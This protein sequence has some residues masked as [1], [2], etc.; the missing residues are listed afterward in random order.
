MGKRNYKSALILAVFLASAI[1]CKGQEMID[2]APREFKNNIRVNITN[3]MIFG[4]NYTVVGYERK[5][6]DYQTASVN[7]GRFSLPKWKSFNNDSIGMSSD[8]SDKGFTMA[9]DYRFYL[10]NENKHQAPRGVYIGPYYSFNRLQRENHWE[11]NTTNYQGRVDSEMKFTANLVGIQLGYQFVLWK[12]LSLDMILFGPGVWFYNMNIDL[13]TDLAPDEIELIY[14]KI[15]EAL[16]EKLPG[17]EL[18]V[19]S[20]NYEKKGAYNTKSGG[21]RLM[22]HLGFLF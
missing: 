4:E 18:L 8:Y 17:H 22:M 12:R 15:N 5:I 19:P 16:A 14:E 6:K 20:S 3:P 21:Y 7:I 2:K 1:Y 13:K 11:L 9:F 10:K